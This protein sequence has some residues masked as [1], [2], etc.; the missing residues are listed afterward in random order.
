MGDKD[1]FPTLPAVAEALADAGLDGPVIERAPSR[2]YVHQLA[3][4]GADCRAACGRRPMVGD[5]L[6]SIAAEVTC[7]ACLGERR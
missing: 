3:G 4:Q 1:H 6:S 7:P 5:R 2:V